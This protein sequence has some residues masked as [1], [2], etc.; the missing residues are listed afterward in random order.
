[1]KKFISNLLWLFSPCRKCKDKEID[2]LIACSCTRSRITKKYK[3]AG[4]YCRGEKDVL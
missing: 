4:N 1:M 3:K 2:G